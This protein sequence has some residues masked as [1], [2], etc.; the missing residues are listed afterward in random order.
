MNLLGLIFMICAIL[1]GGFLFWQ[2]H[3]K[4]GRKWMDSLQ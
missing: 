2:E 3:T 4:A 1:S